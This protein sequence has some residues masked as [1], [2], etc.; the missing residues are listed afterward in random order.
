MDSTS[1]LNISTPNYSSGNHMNEIQV[2][3]NES[4]VKVSSLIIIPPHFRI[5]IKSEEI[6]SE[7]QNVINLIKKLNLA[8]KSSEDRSILQRAFEDLSTCLLAGWDT[9]EINAIGHLINLVQELSDG[10][11]SMADIQEYLC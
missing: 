3:L 4:S 8:I 9:T 7:K 2:P 10:Q 5:C 11:Y 6:F 1:L